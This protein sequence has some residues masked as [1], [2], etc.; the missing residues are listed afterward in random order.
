M[1]ITQNMRSGATLELL[2]TTGVGPA[3]ELE[4]EFAPRLNLITGDNGL[5]KTFLLE[6]AWWVLTGNWAGYEPYPHEDTT[7]DFPSITFQISKESQ[8]DRPQTVK[9]NW[10]KLAWNTPTTGSV[11]PGLSVFAQADGAFAVWDPSKHLLHDERPKVNSLITFS[12]EEIWNGKEERQDNQISSLCNGLIRDW[13]TW[14][15]VDK[16]RF[17]EFSTLLE[18]L[19][20]DPTKELL[21]PGPLTKLPLDDRYIPTLEFPYGN[22]PIVL[23]S[24]GIRRILALAYLLV[25]SWNAHVETSKLMRREPSRSIVLLID[26]MEAHLHPLWQR[27]I[28]PALMNVVKALDSE[29]ETQLIIATHSPLVLASVEPLFNDQKDKLFHLYHEENGSVLLDEVPFIT[30]GRV[31]LWLTSNIFGLKQPRSKV[32]EDTIEKAKALQRK[33]EPSKEE[34]QEVSEA[35]SRVLAPDDQFWPRWTYFAEREGVEL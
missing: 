28:T 34:V 18:R 21:I 35:L 20:P 14:Q 16:D 11:L 13:V 15:S 25:W 7:R 27:V 3:K 22:V 32:A 30:R 23:C 17:A 19:S 5:G 26:E 8:L 4:C 24:E 29:V 1:A 10:N 6:W 33:K 31:D 2:K 12:S 9:Y